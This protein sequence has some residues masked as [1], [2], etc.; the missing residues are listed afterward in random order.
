MFETLAE[1][2]GQSEKVLI[3]TLI[4]GHVV[5]VTTLVVKALIDQANRVQDRLDAESKA[6]IILAEGAAREARI[7]QK[8]EENTQIN[9][10]AIKTANGHNEKIASLTETVSKTIGEGMQHMHVTID[11]EKP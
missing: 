6:K 10:E 4:G 8:I 3:Y 7:N 5:T 2:T 11:R 1:A 9:L